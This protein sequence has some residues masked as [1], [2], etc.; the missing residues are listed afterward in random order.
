[1]RYVG[2][3]S[4]SGSYFRASKNSAVAEFAA[5]AD[6]HPVFKLIPLV[7]S[8]NAAAVGV[9]GANIACRGARSHRF[10]DRRC[11]PG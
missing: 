9:Y 11:G 6:S 7:R 1:M 5:V 3:G 4:A 8:A 2:I 10:P